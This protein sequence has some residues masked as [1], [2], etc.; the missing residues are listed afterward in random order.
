MKLLRYLSILGIGVIGG[1]TATSTVDADSPVLRE[2]VVIS[3]SGDSGSVKLAIESQPEH[4]TTRPDGV[5]G[6]DETCEFLITKDNLFADESAMKM[7]DLY[8]EKKYA[9]ASAGFETL[10]SQTSFNT[11]DRQKLYF[12]AAIARY[13][14]GKAQAPAAAELMKKAFEIGAPLRHVSAVYG[15]KIGYDAKAWDAIVDF[16]DALLNS[17]DYRTYRGIALANL[18]KYEAAATEFENIE[19]YPK[20]IRLDALSARALAQS[21]TSQLK[22]ALETYRRI[23]EIDPNSAQGQLAQEAIM[24]Q[25]DKWP[26]GFTFPR[27]QQKV[28]SS[29]S[30]RDTALA[31]FMAHRSEQAIAAYTK[32][33]KDDKKRKDVPKICDDLYAIARSHVKLRAH[34][35]SLPVFK[36]ALSTCE[37]DELHVKILYPAGK[38]AWN[39]GENA[40]AI[41]W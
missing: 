25:K 23:Y 14:S 6:S 12:L 38:A 13:K 33:L 19:K 41:A 40:Q 22:A 24:A 26:N 20:A 17:E 18:G 2:L 32:L 4:H 5:L 35:K 11:A 39:A 36:E 29:K 10:T 30:A 31:H 28:E 8:K 21:E 1:C 34:S 7:W 27:A 15:T 16:T 3:D 9:D 37:K